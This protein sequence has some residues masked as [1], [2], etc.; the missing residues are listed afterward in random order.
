MSKLS[1]L[2]QENIGPVSRRRPLVSP[3]PRPVP[4]SVVGG[5]SSTGHGNSPLDL[6]TITYDPAKFRE[7]LQDIRDLISKRR[8]DKEIVAELNLSNYSLDAIAYLR[9]RGGELAK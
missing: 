4:E 3:T 8:S 7:L 1:E 2:V 5:R 6:G 9:Q